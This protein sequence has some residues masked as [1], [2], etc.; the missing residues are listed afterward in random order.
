[1]KKETEEWIRIAIED[2]QSAKYLLEKSLYRM[3]CYHAQQTVEKLSKAILVQHDI[4]I[5]RTHNLLDLNNAIKK[6]GYNVPLSDEDT[7]FLNS[8]YRS[9]YPFDAGL[10]PHGEPTEKD[11]EKALDIAKQMTAWSREILQF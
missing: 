5:P 11:A 2:F 6:L 7:V 3:V 1:M 9:R 8:I 10:L 4:D